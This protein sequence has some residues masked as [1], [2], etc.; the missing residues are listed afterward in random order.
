[1]IRVLLEFTFLEEGSRTRGGLMIHLGS[2]CPVL[3]W[4]K[5]SSLKRAS[6]EIKNFL[7][8]KMKTDLRVYCLSVNLIKSIGQLSYPITLNVRQTKI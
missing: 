4:A 8:T 5:H 7:M 6:K 2:S 1:M 3:R